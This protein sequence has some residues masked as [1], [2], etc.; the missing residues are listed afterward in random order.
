MDNY[1]MA[2]LPPGVL[3]VPFEGVT[4]RVSTALSVEGTLGGL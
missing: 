3:K 1:L 4:A 2:A